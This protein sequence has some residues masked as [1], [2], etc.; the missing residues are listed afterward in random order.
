[1]KTGVM[2][3]YGALLSLWLWAILAMGALT[4]GVCSPHL[5]P[6]VEE[7]PGHSASLAPQH[8]V[9]YPPLLTAYITI[10]G[11]APHVPA[12]TEV[13]Q[14]FITSG[15]FGRMFPMLEDLPKLATLG[16]K[17]SVPGDPEQILLLAPDAVLVWS[18]ATGGLEKIGI[19]FERITSTD[20][21]ESW[22]QLGDVIHDPQRADR[23]IASSEQSKAALIKTVRDLPHGKGQRALILWRNSPDVWHIAG[24]AHRAAQYLADLGADRPPLLSFGKHIS[25]GSLQ[26]DQEELLKLDPDIIF[27][28][29][30]VA[31]NDI[32]QTFYD[33]PAM[34]PL[35]AVRTHHIYKEPLGGA[36][37]DGVVE[38]PLILRWYAELL[39]PDQLDSQFR[40][41][42]KSTYLRVY[43]F[44]IGDD[45]LDPAIF[46]KENSLSAN[47]ARFARTADQQMKIRN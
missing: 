18:W 3:R 27:L 13:E 46:L 42:F 25:I 23:L 28:S 1:L 16:R 6:T 34:R 37:M 20:A 29:C 11:Q 22:H 39:Y 30:C 35:K 14:S 21:L 17:S 33:D 32:P 43:D 8:P 4:I 24:D 12:I 38:M 5:S 47:Y 9:I 44:S 40:G 36:R 19:S 7:R 45:E 31:V 41:E 2:N 15:L 10:E 26:I